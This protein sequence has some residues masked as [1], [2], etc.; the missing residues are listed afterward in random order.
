MNHVRRGQI[1]RIIDV[2]SQIDRF[3][4]G[5]RVLGNATQERGHFHARDHFHTMASVLAIGHT[6]TV[7]TGN[8]QVKTKR[9]RDSFFKLSAHWVTKRGS[10]VRI[11]SNTQ[12]RVYT[13]NKRK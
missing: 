9:C 5:A 1:I 8:R 13:L 7:T 10:N 3:G 6:K 4:R 2:L 11:P 12:T